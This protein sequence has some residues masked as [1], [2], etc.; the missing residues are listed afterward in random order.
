MIFSEFGGRKNFQNFRNISNIY[1]SGVVGDDGQVDTEATGCFERKYGYSFEEQKFY[2]RPQ[3]DD[4][5][6]PPD[7][8]ESRIKTLEKA[9]DQ[10]RKTVEQQ[11]DLISQLKLRIEALGKYLK[12]FIF[13][14]F[15]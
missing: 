13:L 9:V 1:R 3:A 4:H 5:E 11:Y 14:I 8:H 15:F 2:R 7:D 12:Y 10:G 6:T